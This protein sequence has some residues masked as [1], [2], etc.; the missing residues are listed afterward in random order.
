MHKRAREGEGFSDGLGIPTELR[1]L[2]AALQRFRAAT[3][4]EAM[5]LW[6]QLDL[7]MPQFAALHVIWQRGPLSGRQLAEQL[8]VSA[9]AV[10]KVCD[11]F[12]ARGYIERVRD[13]VDRRVQWFQLTASGTAI[14]Q[15][16]VALNREHLAPA[17]KGLSPGDRASLTR[18]LNELA[19]CIEAA[20]EPGKAQRAQRSRRPKV[21]FER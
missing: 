14:F 13:K 17:L 21:S 10:V 5:E 15:Q 6:L 11:R 1:P 12:E 7:T 3:A 20:R 4:V 18:I 2:V 16:L 19:G 9:P 8:G